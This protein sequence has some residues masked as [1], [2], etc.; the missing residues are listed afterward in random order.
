MLAQ[1]AADLVSPCL[2]WGLPEV[3]GAGRL[4]RHHPCHSPAYSGDRAE[5]HIKMGMKGLSCPQSKA[6]QWEGLLSLNEDKLLWIMAMLQ[7][8][9][10]GQNTHPLHMHTFTVT[11]Y[12]ALCG[13]CYFSP[14][15]FYLSIFLFISL[16]WPPSLSLS[17]RFIEIHNNNQGKRHDFTLTFI[18]LEK[19][20]PLTKASKM[21]LK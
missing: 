4:C 7:L 15:M 16:F 18:H 12:H 11:G 9:H 20:A 19:T 6:L 10:L 3:P 2:Y 17:F 13:R 1:G 21:T 14:S 8:I 5:V